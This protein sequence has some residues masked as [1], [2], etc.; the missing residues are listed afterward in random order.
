MG[1]EVAH[2]LAAESRDLDL[3]MRDRKGL[4][5]CQYGQWQLIQA[6]HQDIGP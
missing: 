3:N 1:I 5:T 6:F 2:R 4:G